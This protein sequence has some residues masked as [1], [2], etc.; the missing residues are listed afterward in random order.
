MKSQTACTRVDMRLA[1]EDLLADL[2]RQAVSSSIATG[3][4]QAALFVLNLGS[5]IVLARLLTPEDFGLVAMVASVFGFLRVFNEAGL[6]TVT[7]QKENITHQQVSNL[8]WTNVALGGVITAVLVVSAPAVEWFFREPRLGR[9]TMVL[10]VSCLLTSSTVQHLAL[11]KRQMRFMTIALIQVGASVMGV[12]VGIGMALLKCGY[13][14]LVGM[15]LATPAVAFALTW[16]ASRWRPQLPAR[17]IG[18]RS[19][20]D[21]GANLTASTFLWSL[22][23]GSDSVLVGRFFGSAALG[24]YSRAGALLNR[25]LEQAMAPLEAVFVPVLSRLQGQPDRYR[26]AVFQVFDIIA[27]VSLPF[28]GMLLA[29]AHPLTIV[30]LGPRWEGA[31]RILTAFTLVALH[32]PMVIVANWL[33]ES[34]GRGRD[35]LLLSCLNSALT[36]AAFLAGLPFGP[37]GMATSFSLSCLLVQLPM[38]YWIAGRGRLVPTAD[39]WM[40]F[41]EHVPLWGIVCTTTWLIRTLVKDSA[42][43][44]QLIV[45]GPT[46]LLAATIVIC[47]YGPSRRGALTLLE[48][49]REWK[50]PKG[51]FDVRSWDR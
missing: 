36:I 14:S 23:R 33:L 12:T 41:C 31:A 1:T 38:A 8:F 28:S 40:R 46:G 35:C 47:V 18:T 34:Q 45:C 27:V 37:V 24:L 20:L 32:V 43:F 6:S 49:W 7:V 5:V 10:S 26:R 50:D 17:D 51:L 2:K 9:V 25:P 48:V 15:Q 30:V 22:A 39:L 19:L 21:F 3:V 11:L 13:W 42:P 44:T 29:L 16:S 4:G